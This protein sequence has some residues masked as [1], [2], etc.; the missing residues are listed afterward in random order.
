MAGWAEVP[1]KVL[2]RHFDDEQI[3]EAASAL[4]DEFETDPSE[5]IVSLVDEIKNDCI[6]FDT[7][8]DGLLEKPGVTIGWAFFLAV[9]LPHHL[10]G[11]HVYITLE[12]AKSDDCATS[13]ERLL[14]IDPMF[15]RSGAFIERMKQ[16]GDRGDHKFINLVA[17]AVTKHERG[18]SWDS[19]R[20]FE[21]VMRDLLQVDGTAP[22][23]HEQVFLLCTKYGGSAFRDPATLRAEAAKVRKRLKIVPRSKNESE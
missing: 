11:D 23:S 15:M 1:K 18:D 12:N 20:N 13:W 9:I 5:F 6:S 21:A 19:E 22:M 8:V 16:A 7:Y 4:A 3:A 10:A 2:T 17:R 14:R